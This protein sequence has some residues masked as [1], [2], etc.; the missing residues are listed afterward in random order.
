MNLVGAPA[1]G[2]S[3]RDKA[4][5]WREMRQDRDRARRAAAGHPN[6]TEVCGPDGQAVGYMLRRRGVPLFYTDRDEALRRARDDARKGVGDVA[7][8]IDPGDYL[9]IEDLEN[10]ADSGVRATED[11]YAQKLQDAIIAEHG[12]SE[13]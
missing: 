4:A 3:E 9:S 8:S 1:R 6:V 5:R 7:G 2:V 11:A 12:A 10:A 13:E